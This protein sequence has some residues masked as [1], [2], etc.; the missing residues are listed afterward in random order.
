MKTLLSGLVLLLLLAGCATMPPAL[1]PPPPP[2]GPTSASLRP[3]TL[4][5]E[6][7]TDADLEDLP[8]LMTADA[9]RAMGYVVEPFDF[10]DNNLTIQA[11]VQGN[12]DFGDVGA[13]NAWA[14]VQRGAKIVTVMDSTAVPVVIV[15]AP[16]IQKCADLEG[17]SL[18]VPSVTSNRALLVK[19]YVAR[20][21]PGTNVELIAIASQNDELAALAAGKIDSGAFSYSTWLQFQR[22][23]ITALHVLANFGSEFPGL[24]GL[25]LITRRELVA[26]SPETV[27]DVIRAELEA[28]RK[29]QDSQVFAQQLVKYMK[30]D[31]QDAQDT[32]QFYYDKNLWSLDGGLKPEIVQANLDFLVE[33]G[34]I[35]AGLKPSEVVDTSLLNVVRATMPLA[36]PPPPPARPQ[37]LRLEIA[38]DKDVTD[39]PRLM[40]ADA[41]REQGYN[42]EVLSFA[43]NTLSTEALIRGE[44]DFGNIS[45]GIVWAAI[46]QGAR[47]VSLVN[48]ESNTLGIAAHA[49]VTGCADLDGKRV[50][51]AS[52]TSTQGIMLNT[53]VKR[54][55]PT[56]KFEPIIVAG[57][58]N[59]LVALKG[60]QV[61]A[62]TIDQTLV[63][64]LQREEQTD[65]HMVVHFNQEF[66]GLTGTS[67]VTRREL[68]EKYPETVKDVVRA[69]LVARR[70]LQDPQVFAEQIVKYLDMKPDEARA[71]A[72]TYLDEKVWDLNGGYTFETLKSNIQFFVEAG[73]LKPGLTP[74]DV[75]DLAL[76]NAVVE[77]IGRK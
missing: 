48:G 36:L 1:P 55:C 76:L 74:N 53:Y 73:T 72:Q 66:P 30:M 18:A 17:K 42:V 27:K 21:C 40:A 41:L 75:A 6:L 61:D 38:T 35:K 14:A 15:A 60:G 34:A 20:T 22:K 57:S 65:I 37:V 8:R 5:I 23:E 52:T 44:L 28:R 58:N 59:R 13:A 39:L 62:A 7:P 51:I 26:Q 63:N 54:N 2:A 69:I 32:G 4:R 33:S 68:V 64:E 25:T 46:Q 45:T 50:A 9:L 67:N 11:L 16:T 56:A 24:G 10:A 12:L 49:N 70:K 47:L 3:T 29:L 19:K 77:E 71:E 43:D 31:P